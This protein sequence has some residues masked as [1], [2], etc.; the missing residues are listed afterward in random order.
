MKVYLLSLYFLC[1]YSMSEPTKWEETLVVN[2]FEHQMTLATLF[3]LSDYNVSSGQL[4]ATNGSHI[5]GYSNFLSRIPST[6]AQEDNLIWML[7]VYSNTQYESI[8]LIFS[9]DNVTFFS[10]FQNLTFEK[11]AHKFSIAQPLESC[12]YRTLNIHQ[13]EFQMTLSFILNS[14]QRGTLLAVD[15]SNIIGEMSI[16]TLAPEDYLHANKLTWMMTIYSNV[17]TAMIDILLLQNNSVS[18]AKERLLFEKNSH[19][20]FTC[21]LL[22]RFS[23]H[24]SMIYPDFDGDGMLRLAD[25][26]YSSEVWM[27]LKNWTHLVCKNGDFDKD[28]MFRL[29][30]AV[31]IAEVWSGSRNNR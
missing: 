11:D 25:A 15:G 27:G 18:I 12:P 13:Y 21:P 24:P 7:T 26:V 20:L 30:D 16:P 2:D 23:K 6:Y 28:G 10:I 1:S 31:L 8:N 5:L 19:E 17:K 9:G 3:N 22:L 14:H 29:A 4:I